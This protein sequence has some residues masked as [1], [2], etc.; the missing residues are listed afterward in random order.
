MLKQAYRSAQPEMT[1]YLL[2]SGARLPKD[3]AADLKTC[4]DSC[5]NDPKSVGSDWHLAFYAG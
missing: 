1:Q 5:K 4:I 2:V 3:A